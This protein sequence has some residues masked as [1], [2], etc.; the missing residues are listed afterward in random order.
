MSGFKDDKACAF[1]A[2]TRIRSCYDRKK[3]AFAISNRETISATAREIFYK[4]A[5]YERLVEEE[6][7][8]LYRMILAVNDN[9]NRQMLAFIGTYMFLR[10]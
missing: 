8:A 5:E 1:E 7:P 10:R 3:K 9:D 4:R 6:N 2:P